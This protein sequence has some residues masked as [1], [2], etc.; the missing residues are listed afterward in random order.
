MCQVG[1]WTLLNPIQSSLHKIASLNIHRRANGV[2]HRRILSEA[3]GGIAFTIILCL[4]HGPLL[5]H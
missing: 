1:R 3:R 2:V 5:L 4:N